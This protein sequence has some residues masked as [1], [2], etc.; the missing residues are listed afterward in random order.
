MESTSLALLGVVF[1]A[2]VIAFLVYYFCIRETTGEAA[3]VMPGSGTLQT[4]V[5]GFGGK[6]RSCSRIS[7]KAKSSQ[8]QAGGSR[9]GS[10]QQK[11]KQTG[12][13]TQPNVRTPQQQPPPKSKIK[14]NHLQPPPPSMLDNRFGKMYSKILLDVELDQPSKDD[15]DVK[16]YFEQVVSKQQKQQKVDDRSRQSKSKVSTVKNKTAASAGARHKP[17]SVGGAIA[18]K[19][20][21]KTHS[22]VHSKNHDDHKEAINRVKK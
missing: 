3:A 4:A 14:S 9:A 6:V 5:G 18:G 15:I 11:S 20:H 17:K 2:V 13:A 10:S 7:P 19:S 16:S 22:K 8:Q 1:A 12:Q 21:L